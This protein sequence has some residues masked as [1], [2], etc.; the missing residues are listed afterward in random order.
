MKERKKYN[1]IIN[2]KKASND[3]VP[4]LGVDSIALMYQRQKF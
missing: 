3:R 1:S 2:K 4:L